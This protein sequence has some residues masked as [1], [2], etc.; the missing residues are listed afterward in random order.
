MS[1]R[2]MLSL[3]PLT[4]QSIRVL[5]QRLVYGA[6]KGAMRSR[7]RPV[8]Q[9]CGKCNTITSHLIQLWGINPTHTT[10]NH[11]L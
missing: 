3:G 4:A 8:E 2:T 9:V 5:S 6:D 10:P 1:P 11:A 7:M